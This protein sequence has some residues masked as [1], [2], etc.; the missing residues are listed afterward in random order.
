MQRKAIYSFLCLLWM[1]F[2]LQLLH[3]NYVELNLEPYANNGLT[4]LE[5]LDQH[6]SLFTSSLG[7]Q[8]QSTLSG[9]NGSFVESDT[10]QD[11]MYV[12]ITPN[13]VTGGV[14]NMISIGAS[15][16]PYTYIITDPQGNILG[17][18]PTPTVDFTTAPAG[19]CWVYG[20]S[21]EG[22]LT[23]M[24]GQNIHTAQLADS[25]AD[26]SNNFVVV[27]REEVDGGT[28]KTNTH[29]DTI[30]L[31]YSGGRLRFQMDSV[32]AGSGP[33]AY[34]V[35][36]TQGNILGL[37]PT[38]MIDF[39]NAGIGECWVWG[40][41]YTGNLTA[42]VGDNVLSTSL[43]DGCFDLSDNFVVALRDSADGGV[44]QSELG[45]DTL[46]IC[47]NDP[48]AT[49]VYKFDST[50]TFGDEFT[51]LVTNDS[52]I[53]LGIPPGDMVDFAGAGPGVCYVWGLSYHGT[54][55]AQVGD[56]I[57]QANLCTGCFDLSDNFITVIREEVD[58]GMVQSELGP[59][60]LSVCYNDPTAP[61]VFKFDSTGASGGNFTYVVTDD[62]ANILGVPPADM[63]NFAGAGPGIC[64][65]WGLSYTGNLTAMVGQNAASVA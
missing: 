5:T 39:T 6:A 42:A 41:N 35:T 43:S 22:N 1:V 37:P 14:F 24:V 9:C 10:W 45:P 31:C 12:C 30:Q 27:L 47:Y 58:G 19:E 13:G 8:P 62:Q 26:L 17:L 61:T 25:C 3:A 23:A 64:Y 52:G 28:V 16:N 51:Y 46:N 57:F 2:G 63:V 40:V 20:L 15:P 48:T 54:L 11:T 33:Y 4:A 49:T 32:N 65:V 50:M 56:D 18:P 60:T 7:Y 38:H 55:T 59:D 36:D 21:Y 53:I 44:V 29:V 34:I